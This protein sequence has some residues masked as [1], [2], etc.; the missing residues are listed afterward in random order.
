MRVHKD[1]QLLMLHPDNVSADVIQKSGS[2]SRLDALRN[3]LN[4]VGN[5]VIG[6]DLVTPPA[7]AEIE[8][9]VPKVGET[10]LIKG[11]TSMVDKFEGKTGSVVEYDVDVKRSLFKV[12]CGDTVLMLHPSN[13]EATC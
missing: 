7:L 11:L 12:K 1:D 5:K 4:G 13:V 6:T 10:V 8:Y 3:S 9:S 2:G